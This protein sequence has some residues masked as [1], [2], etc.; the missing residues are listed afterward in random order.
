MRRVTIS[1]PDGL[2]A[3]L[4]EVS[5]ATNEHGYGPAHWVTDVVAS[6]LASRRLPRVA[7]GSLGPR[8]ALLDDVMEREVYPVHFPETESL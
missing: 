1:L 6:E 4:Q 2:Y 8:L 3:E 7:R 5:A